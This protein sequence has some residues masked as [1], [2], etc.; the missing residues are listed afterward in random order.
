MKL[1]FDIDTN[2]LIASGKS[3]VTN[4]TTNEERVRKW[5]SILLTK[6]DVVYS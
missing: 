3:N 2:D 1:R 5:N 6:Y 4:V